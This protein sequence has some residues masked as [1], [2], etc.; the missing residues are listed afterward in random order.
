MASSPRGV[1]GKTRSASRERSGSEPVAQT[2]H[3]ETNGPVRGILAQPRKGSPPRA[4][5]RTEMATL[6]LKED[7]L[8]WREVDGEVVVLVKDTATYVSVNAAG[9]TLW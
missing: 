6:K 4:V 2:R 3:F 9:A 5:C 8:A 7:A 1:D